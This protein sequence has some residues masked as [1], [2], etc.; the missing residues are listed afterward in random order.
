M[1]SLTPNLDERAK[2]HP[3][4]VEDYFCENLFF[5]DSARSFGARSFHVVDHARDDG[6]ILLTQPKA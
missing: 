6:D 2:S 1:S 5:H 3:P 4:L